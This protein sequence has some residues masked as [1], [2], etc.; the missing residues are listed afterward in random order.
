MLLLQKMDQVGLLKLYSNKLI[1][2]HGGYKPGKISQLFF[3]PLQIVYSI[4]RVECECI[5]NLAVNKLQ[6]NFELDLVLL[7]ILMDSK[8]FSSC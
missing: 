7:F 5:C 6:Y 4:L 8:R 3:K 1:A 2:I